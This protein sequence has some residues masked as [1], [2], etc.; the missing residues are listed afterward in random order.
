MAR[1]SARPGRTVAVFFI[2]LAVAYG[3]VALVGTW[4]PALGLDL[5]GGTQI[6]LTANGQ[7]Q[8][9]T[10]STRP[11]TSSTARQR[12]GCLRGR[13][14]HPGQQRDRRPGAR[15]HQEQPGRDRRSARRSSAS[16]WSRRCRR[17]TTADAAA[18][19]ARRPR[20]P[21]PASTAAVAERRSR[22]DVTSRR[23]SPPA[24]TARRR[25]SA[26]TSRPRRRRQEH[27]LEPELVS[28]TTPPTGGNVPTST[29]R[30]E[31]HRG[32]PEGLRGRPDLDDQPR[33][34]VGGGLQRLHLP[35][36]EA[37]RRRPDHAA[38]D[39]RRRER[40]QVPALAGADR[41]H[42]DLLGHRQRARLARRARCSGRSASS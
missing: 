28:P 22:V 37:G 23:T 20:R 4:K 29:S 26:R 33:P 16:A 14:D 2:G 27:D 15:R 7:R 39:L 13:G 11:P 18:V 10:T 9:R 5:E 31:L 25:C 41:G 35:V 21:A 17:R 19:A 6:T 30:G 3:L 34:A 12:L 40:Q 36:D 24:R 32:E 1:N 38:G 42:R 8:P